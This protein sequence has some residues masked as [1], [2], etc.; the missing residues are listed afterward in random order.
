MA[1]SAAAAAGGAGSR[2]VMKRDCCGQL[3]KQ[4]GWFLSQNFLQMRSVPNDFH[5]QEIKQRRRDIDQTNNYAELRP[6]PGRTCGS[7]PQLIHRER[8]D[9]LHR[10]SGHSGWSAAVPDEQS[11]EGCDLGNAQVT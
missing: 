8:L 1:C 9:C 3:P 5:F 2:D 10:A 7:Q 11:G 4:E 6:Q